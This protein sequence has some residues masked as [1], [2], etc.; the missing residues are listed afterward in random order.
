M[1]KDIIEGKSHKG[2]SFM[3][4]NAK[5]LNKILTHQIQQHIKRII[6]HEQVGLIPGMQG[7]FNIRK[8]N[9]IHH[10]ITKEENLYIIPTDTGKAFEN[11]HH[12]FIIKTLS[13]LEEKFFTLIMNIYK[14]T[15]KY[16]TNVGWLNAAWSVRQGCL[17]SPF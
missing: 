15:C 5:T 6:H 1:E 11:L 9:K 4:K 13:K 8:I 14:N 12:Q 16:A 7:W 17:L 3:D 2:V 10:S